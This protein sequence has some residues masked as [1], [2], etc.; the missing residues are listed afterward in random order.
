MKHPD[1]DRHE[2]PH[3]SLSN[4]KISRPAVDSARLLAVLWFAS[5]R[6]PCPAAVFMHSPPGSLP[7][8]HWQPQPTEWAA[9]RDATPRPE[10]DRAC[11]RGRGGRSTCGG[12]SHGH[13]A[14]VPK[15]TALAGPA[16]FI[17]TASLASPLRARRPQASL[18]LMPSG[19]GQPP[20]EAAD[21]NQGDGPRLA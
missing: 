13:W 5:L 21:V 10:A 14:P 12:K 19:P 11:R 1:S 6:P 8:C 7:Q 9:D 18:R 2:H 16:V 4:L 20:L 3:S 17:D 15:H